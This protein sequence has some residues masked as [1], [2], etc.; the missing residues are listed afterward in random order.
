MRLFE[1]HLQV[2]HMSSSISTEE[3]PSSRVPRTVQGQVVLPKQPLYPQKPW[4]W[5][6]AAEA[7][8]LSP[9]VDL[10]VATGLLR[11]LQAQVNRGSVES[12][13]AQGGKHALVSQKPPP[14]CITPGFRQ[15]TSRVSAKSEQTSSGQDN[16]SP[17]W[18]AM[19]P[20]AQGECAGTGS[21]REAV[22]ARGGRW[23]LGPGQT[24]AHPL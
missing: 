7:T 4:V 11:I 9:L 12:Q 16:P 18:H 5:L 13:P 1:G 2:P 17:K 14:T 23:T 21:V 3:K 19:L 6:A 10:W 24:S 8:V 15:G 20:V 22:Q